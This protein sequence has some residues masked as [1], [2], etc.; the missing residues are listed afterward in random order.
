[1]PL[2]LVIPDLL[3]PRD[4]PE[5]LR[6]L[7]FPDA[8]KWLARGA[9]R[10]E[11]P[12]GPVEWLAARY[13]VASPAPVAAIALAGEGERA[14]GAW[15]RA[16]P[17]H[18]RIETGQVRLHGPAALEV[19]PAEAAALV[20]A[21]QA[22][23]ASDGLEFRLVAP[24]RWYLR[25]AGRALPQ[26]T[27]IDEAIG[28]DVYALMP[29]GGGPFSWRAAMNEAQM[30]LCAHEVNHAREARRRPTINS[31]WLW[32]EGTAPATLDKP[33]SLVFARDA[34]A[35]GLGVLSGAEVCDEPRDVSEVVGSASDAAALVVIDELAAAMRRGDPEAWTA[36]AHGVNARWFAR[37]AEALA[38]FGSLRVIL[39]AAE[40]TQIATLTAASRWRWFN[41]R[42]P[43]AAYA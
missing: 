30:V 34:F 42:K 31:V 2:D 3:L 32:G 21:L 14:E 38:A 1:M 41:A 26:T 15:L 19:E 36:A 9:L 33:Y 24:E 11:A 40:G 23:F 13:G 28:R 7:R 8:E 35:R 17:V 22:H 18:L 6:A 37:V 29:E 10:R 4:A 5:A 27:P 20:A 43:L 39:P 16:D 12:R 25:V